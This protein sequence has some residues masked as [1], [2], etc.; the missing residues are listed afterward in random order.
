MTLLKEIEN[1]LQLN[2]ISLYNKIE[3]NCN[4]LLA[5]ATCKIPD[6]QHDLFEELDTIVKKIEILEADIQRHSETL[7][8]KEVEE[9]LN[10]FD[11]TL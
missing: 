5:I 7:Q 9:I 4:K 2:D 3:S 11:N 1:D 8:M 10:R 6:G